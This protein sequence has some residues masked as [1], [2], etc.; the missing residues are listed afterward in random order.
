MGGQIGVESEPGGGSTFW[1]TGALRAAG[2][3]ALAAAGRR[4]APVDVAG[5][6]VLVV[7]DNATN[8]SV[9]AGMLES[10][11]CRHAEVDGAAAGAR[12]AARRARRGRPVPHRHPR[13]DDAGDG[14]RG[15]SARPI[16][17]DPELWPT[18]RSS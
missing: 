16:K 9:V 8:R 5:V 1:F 12:G 13:H 7:D 6:R 10:W 3:A 14:R 17:G 15:R 2:P 4:V 18:A 11:G